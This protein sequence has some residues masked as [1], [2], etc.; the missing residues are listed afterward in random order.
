MA[1]MEFF[2]V[3]HRQCTHTRFHMASY[4]FLGPFGKVADKTK[5]ESVY[6]S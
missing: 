4:K 3:C 2:A 5:L 1:M 6:E